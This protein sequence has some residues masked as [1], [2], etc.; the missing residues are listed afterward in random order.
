[1]AESYPLSLHDALPICRGPLGRGGAREGGA[2]EGERGQGEPARLQE[3]AARGAVRGGGHGGSLVP[4][5]G[6]SERTPGCPPR[7]HPAR[8]RS[9]EH[10]SELQSLAYLV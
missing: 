2:D 6:S 8:K 4:V 9:E 5:E 7:L 10:T 3:G 1:P